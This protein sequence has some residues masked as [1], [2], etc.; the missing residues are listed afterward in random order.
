MCPGP[1]RFHHRL[2]RFPGDAR[3]NASY[4]LA[5]FAPRT[6]P[7]STPATGSGTHRPVAVAAAGRNDRRK[8][9]T[10]FARDLV[11]YFRHENS[12][13]AFAAITRYP[14]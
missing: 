7:G 3:E 1:R 6:R 10:G 9:P 11:A 2:V 5:R 14:G 8:R 12:R 4:S 13:A